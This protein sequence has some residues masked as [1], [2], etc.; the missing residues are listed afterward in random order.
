[1]SHSLFNVLRRNSRLRLAATLLC[2]FAC[3]LQGFVAQTHVHVRSS[4]LSSSAFH[5]YEL[6]VPDAGSLAATSDEDSP[7]HNGR[8]GSLT[9]PLCQIALHGGVGP[10]PTFALSLPLP[11]EIA[12]AHFEQQLSGTFAAVSFNW[13]GRAPPLT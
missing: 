8:D 13:Q 9:C 3:T 11:I 6:D 12:V 1:L 10:A 5:G 2:L 7:K 4:Q